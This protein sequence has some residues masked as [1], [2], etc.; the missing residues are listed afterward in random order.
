MAGAKAGGAEAF[1]ERLT[2]SLHQAGEDVRAIIRH[3]PARLQRLQAGGVRAAGAPF[4]GPFD[5]STRSALKAVM[6]EF[7]PQVTLAWMNRGA[8]KTPHPA[9]VAGAG[10]LAGR[11]GG[12]YNLK[13]YRHCD[14]L[15]GNT[16]GIVRWL[17][18]Q[19]WPK[20]RC[21]YLPN[22][23]ESAAMAPVGRATHS[24]PD[25]A[26]VVLALGRLH[27]NKAFDVLIR[28]LVRLPGAV[29][30]LAGDGPER[31]A[32]ETLARECGVMERVRFLGWRDD[33]PALLAACDLLCCPS[34]H[35][36]LGNVIL[37]SFAHDVPVVAASS[38]GPRELISDGV[39][40]L[41][42]PVDD[43]AALAA[44]IGRVLSSRDLAGT[45]AAGGRT[46]YQSSFT[47]DAVTGAYRAFFARVVS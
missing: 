23:A 19:G 30:W 31:G 32:L 46:L 37:E 15:I 21:H 34:R 18:E 5:F 6:R 29:L 40:G 11:L 33:V 24:T 45:L 1:F 14:H 7:R 3:D 44:A 35:E 26:R 12:Y 17:A 2:L 4:G 43:P 42:V 8:A 41:L 25:E 28:A 36:P 38:D 39:N 20:D 16:K 9:R 22:F 27:T 13:Y 10:V 47:R